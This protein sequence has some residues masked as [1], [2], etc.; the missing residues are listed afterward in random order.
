MKHCH[1]HKYSI[2][3]NSWEIERTHRPL[4]NPL[5]NVLWVQGDWQLASD[6]LFPS[7]H[8]E[9]SLCIREG[10]PPPGGCA[11]TTNEVITEGR[12]S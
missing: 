5:A 2:F 11:L 7:M 6:T 1:T 8:H 10:E 12:E 4:T 3:L 9:F